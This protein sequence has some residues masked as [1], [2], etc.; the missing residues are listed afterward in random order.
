[1]PVVGVVVLNFVLLWQATIDVGVWVG[2]RWAHQ[3][4][5]A[6]GMVVLAGLAAS[7]PVAAGLILYH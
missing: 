5:L 3:A 6:G 7:I 2:L 4:L 1:V